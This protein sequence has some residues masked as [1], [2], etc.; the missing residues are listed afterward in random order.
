MSIFSLHVHSSRTSHV[1]DHIQVDAAH[2]ADL[3]C[4]LSNLLPAGDTIS[5][6]AFAR[7][8]LTYDHGVL[9]E[10]R[11]WTHFYD[12]DSNSLSNESIVAVML[13]NAP[14]HKDDGWSA[15]PPLGSPK[16]SRS[17]LAS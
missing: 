6:E 13:Q 3:C 4:E 17:E 1:F 11:E 5:V 2:A 10:V 15:V 9:T 8:W 7:L 12:S 16:Q 14:R